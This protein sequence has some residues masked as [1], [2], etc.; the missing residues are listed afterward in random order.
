MAVLEREVEILYADKAHLGITHRTG[1]GFGISRIILHARQKRLH[2][3]RR[4]QLHIMTQL[5]KLAGPI[6]RRC[7]GFKADHASWQFGKPRQHLP[8]F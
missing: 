1:N 5:G 6:M 8:A 7:T 2:P 3:L 4:D